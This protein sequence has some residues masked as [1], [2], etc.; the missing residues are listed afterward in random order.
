MAVVARRGLVGADQVS[1]GQVL[2]VCGF[3][4]QFSGL[5]IP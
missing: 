4:G 3:I 1:L 5:T 2:M